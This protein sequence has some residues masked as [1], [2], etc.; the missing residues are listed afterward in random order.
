MAVSFALFTSDPNLLRCQLDRLEGQVLLSANGDSENAVGL[1]SYAQEEVLSQRFA[2]PPTLKA[3]ADTWQGSE[4]DAVAYHAQ[5][6][7]VSVPL[8]PSVQPFRYRS[9]L[10]A[11]NGRVQEF[12][13]LKSN[14]LSSLP[15]FLRRQLRGETDSEAAFALFLKLLRDTGRTDDR[16]LEPAIGAQLLEKTTG[17]LQQLSTD[18]G[19]SRLCDLNFLVTNG[20]MLLASRLGSEPLY[21]SLLEG[22]D[23]CERCGI[24][25]ATAGHQTEWL[26]RQHRR[27]R[28]V[29]VASHVARPQSFM[30]L[31]TGFAL[32]VDRTLRV[33]QLPL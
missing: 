33:Q 31:R 19:A 29:V 5:T 20:R 23:R 1:G 11:H 27:Q 25:G 13:R 21:Y 7:P 10:F 2:H 8:E 14:L 18:A 32:A 17:L 26:V 22:S 9:W 4:S 12:G 6:L 3:L 30:E 16:Q 15:E 28:T 24:D